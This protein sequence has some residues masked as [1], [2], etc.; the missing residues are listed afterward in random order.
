MTAS[1]K[2]LIVDDDR[3][4]R[5]DTRRTLNAAG[6]ETLE[7]Q[8][9]EEALRAVREHNPDLMLLDVN[10]P[11]MDGFAVCRR[12]KADP[13]LARTF[14]IIMSGE[15]ADSDSYIDGLNMG[16]DGYIGRPIA[17]RELLA[18][19]QAMLR[20][21]AAEDAVRQK[22][23]QL[24]DLIASNIDGMLVSDMDG[25]ALF[26]NP[27][28]CD[29]LNRAQETL[30]GQDVGLP[31]S[32]GEPTELELLRPDGSTR[33]VEMRVV[34]ID[35]Q[36]QP[37]RL[38]ALRDISERKQLELRMEYLATHDGLTG[39]PNRRLFLDRLNLA[40]E[41]ARREQHDRAGQF[42][43]VVMMLDID[44]FKDVNDTLGH[45]QGDLLLCAVADRLKNSLR[46]S[47]TVARMGGDEFT[48]INENVADFETSVMFARK[49]SNFLSEPYVFAEHTLKVTVSIGVSLFPFDGDNS[50]MLLKRADIAMYRAKQTGNS[51]QFYS[52]LEI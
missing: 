27:A 26:A 22:E 31:M 36:G 19:V 2:I 38:A 48:L 24:R 47:D 18:H 39:L 40:L 15:R 33:I 12:V 50:D 9:G 14:I 45:A 44:H 35:W 29:L 30:V 37:A 5:S 11:K 41:R 3:A 52:L 8:D 10:M 21:K 13:A 43:A 4:I 34:Q 46:K 1:A 16:A 51:F 23:Q 49:V 42:V 17:N 6:Y 28:A 7:A 25:R 32:A 20:I